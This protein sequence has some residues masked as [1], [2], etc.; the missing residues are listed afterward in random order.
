[1]AT[2]DLDFYSAQSADSR[3]SASVVVPIV[4]DLFR[5]RSA[6]DFGCGIGTW[7]AE[8][9][10]MGVT[11]YEGFD[12]DYVPHDKLQIPADRFHAADL[13][14]P[15]PIDR[16]F[17]VAMSV[18]V[19]EHLPPSSAADFIAS[20][21]A[22]APIVLFSA[23]VPHQ[24]G[25][26]HINEQWPEYWRRLFRQHGYRAVDAIRP[27]I[28]GHPDVAWWYQQNILLYCHPDVLA[29]NAAAEPVPDSR[30]LDLVH[31]SFFT[32]VAERDPTLGEVLPI[33]PRMIMNSIAFR[34]GRRR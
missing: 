22:A 2:Y 27:R 26:H 25:T 12:G 1:M 9:D 3:R 23:A 20:L 21:V 28:W 31:P 29:A 18:E 19:A 34:L 16:R 17:D 24:G 7:L 33:L 11:D 30:R 15:P 5:P 13:T 4:V 14:R 6:V 10:A 8:F 32:Y